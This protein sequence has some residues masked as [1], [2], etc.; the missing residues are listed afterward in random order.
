MLHTRVS[1]QHFLG[2]HHWA[3]TV[4]LRPLIEV[5]LRTGMPA[6]MNQTRVFLSA[7]DCVSTVSEAIC[8]KSQRLSCTYK[9]QCRLSPCNSPSENLFVA[10]LS[11]QVLL[12]C[13]AIF[14]FKQS[15]HIIRKRS[16][17]LLNIF[18][19]P[20]NANADTFYVTTVSN[21]LFSPAQLN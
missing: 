21:L 7:P 15:R 16:V 9:C 13:C 4:R 8:F 6:F 17:S 2:I 18:P 3:V 1:R 14:C 11:P 5:I 20:V 12:S 10:P 19:A